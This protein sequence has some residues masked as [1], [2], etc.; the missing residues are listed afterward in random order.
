MLRCNRGFSLIT[1]LMVMLVVAVVG[2]TMVSIVVREKNSLTKD[3]QY[4][5]AAHLARLGMTRAIQ[6]IKDDTDWSDNGGTLYDKV[7]ALGG[8]YTVDMTDP[9]TYSITITSVG[10]YEDTSY[11]LTQ[12]PARTSADDAI[13]MLDISTTGAY[14][15]AEALRGIRLS[16]LSPTYNIR[17]EKMIVS[18][19]PD[20]LNHRFKRIRFDGADLWNHETGTPLGD[21]PRGTLVYETP[22]DLNVG[23]S[24][25][26][27][28]VIFSNENFEDN[29]VSISL[30]F[31]LSDGSTA[32][33]DFYWPGN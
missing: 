2:T 11:T 21:Q 26:E 33:T 16:N 32:Y 3:S 10:R 9:A 25:K 30:F 13:Y 27:L 23:M 28:R 17:I 7:A 8:T 29:P 6:A 19:Y 14:V 20:S 18:W 12:D 15:D 31:L 5:T 4:Q 22:Y 24:N 1:T